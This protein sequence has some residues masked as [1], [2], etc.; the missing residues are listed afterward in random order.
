MKEIED[1]EK[2]LDTMIENYRKLK[3][4]NRELWSKVKQLNEKILV[5][6]KEKEQLERHWKTTSVL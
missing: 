3:E 2:M 1:L 6:E 4:E 5:L